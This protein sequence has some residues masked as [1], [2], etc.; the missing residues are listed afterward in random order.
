MGSVGI[1]SAWWSSHSNDF[2][3]L[4]E[5]ERRMNYLPFLGGWFYGAATGEQRAAYFCSWGLLGDAPEPGIPQFIDSF[6]NIF[7]RRR[8]S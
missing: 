5:I 1:R 6:I 8:R 2:S 3:A 4:Q 7:R